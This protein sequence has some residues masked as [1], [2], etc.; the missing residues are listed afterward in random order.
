MHSSAS[1]VDAAWALGIRTFD[2]APFYRL[3]QSERELGAALAARPREEYTLSTKVGRVLRDGE[4]V[5]DL[6]PDG[7]RTSFAESRERLGVERVD[8]LLL[9]DPEDHMAEA[10]RALEAAR[11]LAPVVGVGTNYVAVALE[12]VQRGE[13]DVVMLAGRY[14]LLDRSGGDELLPLCLERGVPVLAAG[15]FNSGVLAGGSTF[16][17]VAAPAD[18]LERRSELAE[19]C[20]RWDVP[21]AAAALQFPLRHPAVASVVVGA[22]SAEEIEEDARLLDVA[23]P[24][25]VWPELESVSRSWRR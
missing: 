16:D 8:T 18:V 7:I 10:P 13:V 22:R 9:H 3:G 25:A 6:S 15:A 2:T 12:L 19:V 4:A 14:T 11:D 21:L 17:Y 23:I 24:D 5:F 20:A 1:A